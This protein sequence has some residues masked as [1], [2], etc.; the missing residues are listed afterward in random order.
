M[1]SRK[2]LVIAVL[3]TFCLSATLFMIMPS[4]SQREYDPWVDVNDD[5]EIDITDVAWS[6]YLFGTSGDPTKNVNVT[7]WLG[8]GLIPVVRQYIYSAPFIV[9]TNSYL[10]HPSPFGVGPG[11]Y[12]TDIL[13]HNPSSTHSIF[14][15]KK[16]VLAYPEPVQ[17]DPIWIGNITLLPDRSIR[18]DSTEIIQYLGP[19]ALYTLNKGFV[20]IVANSSYLDV[21]AVYTVSDVLTAYMPNRPG[22]T[23]SIE[24]LTIMPKPYY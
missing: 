21:I 20:C 9:C 24:T 7:N 3:A 13:I 2:D 19:E 17:K 8:P 1:V 18:I 16:L 15:R 4:R 6:A 23:T 14:I 5:G 10:Q 12:E 11:V 22:N